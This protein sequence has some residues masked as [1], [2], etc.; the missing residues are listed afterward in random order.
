ME[1]IESP[2]EKRRKRARGSADER[3]R[4]EFSEYNLSFSW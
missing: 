4:K 3:Q 2:K 1:L